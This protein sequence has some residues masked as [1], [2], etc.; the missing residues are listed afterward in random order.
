MK[1]MNW[2]KMKLFKSHK[3]EPSEI[4]NGKHAKK[5]KKNEPEIVV[6]LPN[7]PEDVLCCMLAF[8]DVKD[9]LLGAS[10]VSKKWN[11][12]V[13]SGRVYCLPQ[14]IHKID[15]TRNT[16][17]RTE[18]RESFDKKMWKESIAAFTRAIILNPRD[19]LSYFWRAYAY[20]ESGQFDLAVKDFSKS[21]EFEPQDATAY[22]N[23][24]ATYRDMGAPE[25]A[26]RDLR[27][28]L[29]MDPHSAPVHNNV[30]V[31][32]GDMGYFEEAL[33]EYSKAL[34][35]DPNHVVALRNRGRRLEKL[36]RVSEAQV[37]F[38]RVLELNPKDAV[39][40][41]FFEMQHVPIPIKSC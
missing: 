9:L 33:G 21:L 7:L 31:V 29:E 2:R 15:V 4:T 24:G 28:A 32:L 18:G 30:G 27:R 23:R 6:N 8:L 38:G 10:L 12:L 40:L 20:D 17:F 1:L 13:S 25:K 5:S 19:H 3:N 26:L 22:S 34:D 36:G 39:A 41:R 37:D 11:E 14:W 16:K 35:I